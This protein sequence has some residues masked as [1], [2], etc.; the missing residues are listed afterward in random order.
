MWVRGRKQ[1]L[2]AGGR[3]EVNGRGFSAN[4]Y[5]LINFMMFFRLLS[6]NQVDEKSSGIL[7]KG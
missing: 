4:H 2:P 1:V 6:D 5:Q 3:G 7:R